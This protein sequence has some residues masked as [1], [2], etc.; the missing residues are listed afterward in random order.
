MRTLGPRLAAGLIAAG[1]L[2]SGCGGSPEPSPPPKPSKSSSPSASATPT[3]PVLPEAA[4]A[5][6]DAAVESFARYY[7]DLINFAT[8]SGSR[9]GLDTFASD[10]CTSCRRLS[11]RLEQIYGAGGSIASEGWRVTAVDVVPD[12][13]LRRKYVDL[14]IVQSPQILIEKAGAAP[15]RFPG[16]KQTLTMLVAR[17]GSSWVVTRMSL[18][19]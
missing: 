6:T 5:R 2:L 7:V 4:N 1:L 17:R 9:E 16:G 3:P 19:G 15:K 18:A 13:P 10:A 11:T 12:Q 14:A 8:T